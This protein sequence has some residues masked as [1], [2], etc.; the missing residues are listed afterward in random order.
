[1]PHTISL[2][3]EREPEPTTYNPAGP[4]TRPEPRSQQARFTSWPPTSPSEPY[5]D[6]RYSYPSARC[7]VTACTLLSDYS[8][9]T[10]GRSWPPKV[11]LQSIVVLR[12]AVVFMVLYLV[13]SWRRRLEQS[14]RG[15][16]RGV[17]GTT[18]LP[19]RPGGSGSGRA[20]D[21]E[22]GGFDCA[23]ARY[24]GLTSF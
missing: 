4:G 15:R 20:R 5:D 9:L 6:G 8:L 12:S 24:G 10:A 14:R 11:S 13:A 22:L 16:E 1:M 23:C 19:S 3:S 2:L 7:H 18:T 21:Y 17:D